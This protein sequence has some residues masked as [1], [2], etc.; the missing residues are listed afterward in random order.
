[1]GLLCL[2]LVHEA[3]LTSTCTSALMVRQSSVFHS[4]SF[5]QLFLKCLAAC[6]SA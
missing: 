6:G 3:A 5:E 1:M 4:S 2:M